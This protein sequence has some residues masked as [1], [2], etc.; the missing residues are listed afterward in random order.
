M[1]RV[2]IA[3]NMC[4]PYKLQL[5]RFHDFFAA[6]GW[7]VVETPEEADLV[8]VG[9]CAGFDRLEEESLASLRTMHGHGKR[10]VA[11]GCMTRFDPERV[12][13]VHDGP[14]IP[15]N[16]GWR[17]AELI[18][19]PAVPLAD[20]PAPSTFRRKADYRLFDL[21]KRYVSIT[22]G[23]GFECS[24][25]PHRVGVGKLQSRPLDEIV[26]QVQALVAE[27]AR[28]VVLTGLETGGYGTDRGDT[29]PELLA[30]V[31][32]ADPS[33]EV[34][35]A[36]FSPTYVMEYGDALLELFSN[37]RVS[38]IQIPIETTSDRLLDLMGR[39]P[40][41]TEIE[42][43]LLRL[44]A[45]APRTILRTD[46][47]PGFPTETD[48]E[49]EHGAH[50]AARLFDEVAVYGFEMKTGVPL[51]DMH[52]PRHP[53]EVI[54]ARVERVVEIVSAAGRLA[55]RGAQ[56]GTD[57]LFALEARKEEMRRSTATPA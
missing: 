8:L 7:T 13:A 51:D 2:H 16:E 23:C 11:Y 32:E 18:P 12:A 24:Y 53:K 34:H 38:D 56:A 42:P 47:M 30:R 17:V 3:D 29:Y 49:V 21:T 31:L 52:L 45:S 27:G 5:K 35:V 10:V 54:A 6:N 1:T 15:T 37:P 36:Q 40:R 26:E 48:E 39:T 43:F 55:H 33:M 44:R 28:T 57:D 25:C 19:N 41:V 20:I 14:C 22:N 4:T 46:L 50:F 9:T